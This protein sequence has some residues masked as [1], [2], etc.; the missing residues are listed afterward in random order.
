MTFVEVDMRIYQFLKL[1]CDVHEAN[2]RGEYQ[3]IQVDK[4]HVLTEKWEINCFIKWIFLFWIY[5]YPLSIYHLEQEESHLSLST[6]YLSFDV[7]CLLLTS[8]LN[9][10]SSLVYFSFLT[11]ANAR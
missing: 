1:F 9:V 11:K 2:G 10:I 6:D 4:Y 5:I 3:T 7:T 8:I